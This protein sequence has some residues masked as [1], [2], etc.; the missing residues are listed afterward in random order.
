MIMD[1][2]TALQNMAVGDIFRARNSSAA[3]LVCLV[4]AVDGRTIYARRIHTQNDVK[5]DRNTGFE[6]GKHYTKIDRVT[7]F[8]PDIRDIFL[9]VDRKLQ[10][11]TEIVRQ[12]IDLTPEQTVKRLCDHVTQ[13]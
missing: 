7:P 8:P 13:P 3:S 9:E 1:R 6:V 5:F 2:E 10:E 4:T 11:L 12:G